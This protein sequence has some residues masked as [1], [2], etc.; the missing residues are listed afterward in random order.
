MICERDGLLLPTPEVKAFDTD[1]YQSYLAIIGG[2]KET[3]QRLTILDDRKAQ[4]AEA[5]AEGVNP[6][7]RFE[8]VDQDAL[9]SRQAALK[10]WKLDLIYRQDIDPD[11]M[12]LYRWRINE[13]IAN[14]NILLSSAAGDMHNFRRWNE[15]IYGKPDE[16]TFRAALDWV[17]NDADALIADDGQPASVIEAAERVK[18]MLE[19]E[20]G[21][22]EILIPDSGLFQAVQADHMNEGGY[23]DLLLAGTTIPEGKIDREIGE[24]ILQQVLKNLGSDK[25][26]VNAAGST[27]GLTKDGLQRPEK[28]NLP[29]VRFK[30]LAIGHEIGSHELERVNGLNGPI[31]LASDGLDRYELGNEG[32]ALVREQVPFETFDEFGQHVRWRDVLRRHIAIGYGHGVGD[33]NEGHASSDVYAFI[34][35][36]DTMYQSKLSPDDS[37]KTLLAADKKSSELLLRVLKGTDGKGGAYL[38]DQVYLEGHV[39]SWLTAALRGADAISQGDLGKFDINNPRHIAKLQAVGLLPRVE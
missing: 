33:D 38:K 30:G 18:E 3:Y 20:R 25:E 32:R 15:F 24:P 2:E 31:Q 21:Y 14:I 27:W 9:L 26:I 8:A 35:T 34:N 5:I 28:Y 17:A 19:G 29:A 1:L 12:Q 37:E 22:R 10:A 36:I 16:D 4:A 7:L 6:D 23:Y 11:V 13:Q 39:A